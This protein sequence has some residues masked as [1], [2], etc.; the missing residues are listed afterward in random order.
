M[1][2]INQFDD[3]LYFVN[4]ITSSGNS[5]ISNVL[6]SSVDKPSDSATTTALEIKIA[7]IKKRFSRNRSING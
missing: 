6:E 2:L 7:P 5:T 1:A 3:D 4:C